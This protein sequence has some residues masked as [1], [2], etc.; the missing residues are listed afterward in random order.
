MKIRAYIFI[1]FAIAFCTQLGAQNRAQIDWIAFEE[2]ADSLRAKPRKVFIDFY[3]DWCTYCRKMDKQV[4]SKPE[5]VRMLNSDYYAVRMDA[6]TRDTIVF[7]GQIFVNAQAQTQRRGF[8]ELALL[9]GQRAGQFT[10]PIMLVLDERFQLVQ[11]SFQ[12]LTSEELL[13]MLE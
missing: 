1:L 11:R 13:Q 6:E 3:T 12:Y 8:H 10:V 4:F 2:L 5:V 7:D 9:L